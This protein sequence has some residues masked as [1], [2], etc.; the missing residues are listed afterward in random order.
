MKAYRASVLYFSGPAQAVFESDGLL[1][2]GPNAQ[3][4]QVVQAVG[5][6]A[7]LAPRF[8]GVP[9]VHFPGPSSRRVLS[10]CTSITRRLT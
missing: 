6:Y 3:G 7:A 1:V 10:T 5:S 9:I 8:A 4:L 2:V